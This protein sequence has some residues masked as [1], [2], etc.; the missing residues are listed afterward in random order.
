MGKEIEKEKGEMSDAKILELIGPD[1]REKL[2]SN[3]AKIESSKTYRKR[4]Y[5]KKDPLVLMSFQHGYDLLQN[6]IVIRPFI[7]KKYNIKNA[8]ELDVLLFLFPIQ[9]FTIA[10][11]KMLPLK[12]HNIYL[13]TLLELGYADL[14]VKKVEFAG[15]IYKLTDQ[16]MK[17]V[18]DYYAYLSGEKEVGSTVFTNPFLDPK[19]AK[20]DKLRQKLLD[21]LKKQSETS[22]SKFRKN[23]Y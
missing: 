3:R 16:A 12:Q 4:K 15:N 7:L 8:I 10:D 19:A 13:K 23:L 21:K 14:C 2:I 9:F 6:N 11:F 18:R 20:V 1:T 17:I 22:P 5:S